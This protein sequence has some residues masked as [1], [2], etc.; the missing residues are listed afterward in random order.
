MERKK[1][2]P[3]LHPIGESCFHASDFAR[4]AWRLFRRD[5]WHDEAKRITGLTAPLSLSGANAISVVIIAEQTQ[6]DLP[7]VG[8]I[9]QS[10]I[11]FP[12]ALLRAG[13]Y[14]RIP[15]DRARKWRRFAKSLLSL[16]E[17]DIY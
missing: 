3:P 12:G 17:L 4:K 2:I 6:Y 14:D 13:A 5:N 1:I 11:A 16:V 8:S 9:A 10:H 7:V 15:P